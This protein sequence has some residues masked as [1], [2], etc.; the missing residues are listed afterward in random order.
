MD[1]T[2]RTVEA[3]W[4]I[5]GPRITASV[6]K[7]TGDLG[8]A[9]DVAQD[10]VA[11][12][13]AAW[14]RDGVP[15]NPGA[16]LT[17]VATRRAIDAWRRRERLNERYVQI[18]RSL[19]EAS[20]E[21]WEPIDDD[22]LRLVFTACHPALSRESQVALTLR[23][24]GG[25]TS[26]EIA[27]MLLV[28]T[29]TVQ[30]RITRAK[31]TLSAARIPFATP[32]P[33]EWRDRLGSVLGV[34]Y[35]VFT[36]GY[37]ATAGDR[38]IRPDLADEAIRLG[39]VVVSL[40]P[41]EPEALGLLALMEFQRSRFAA[42]ESAGAAVTLADQDRSRWDR[43]QIARAIAILGRADA[44]AAAR[45]HGRGSY[46]LQAAIAER[47]A[48][49]ASV[50]DTDWE[51]I[52]ALYETLVRVSPSPI[53]ELSRAVA[54]SMSSN[55]AEALPIVDALRDRGALRGSHLLPSVRGELLARAGRADE[56]RVELL[57]AARLTTNAAQQRV[58]REKAASL[59]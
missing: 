45:G 3:V 49:A 35:L 9:E 1:D 6:A 54:V 31:K 58:L 53:A 24:V 20:D 46:A 51:E 32:D 29:P 50:D 18:G 48:V 26:A 43:G 17:A 27:R 33:G 4:R 40:L 23:V 39:R 11:E 8:L 7:M 41:R 19:D 34:I 30:A 10:A 56:A 37:A 22:V 14:P 42:R 25:L 59:T 38:W 36:E 16:W 57:E 44:A 52:V 55:A 2:R 12:A 15:V 13:L 21:E 5:E 28:E 47:H